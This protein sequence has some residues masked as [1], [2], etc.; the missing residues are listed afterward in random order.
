[1]P[2]HQFNTKSSSSINYVEVMYKTLR[3]QENQIKQRLASNLKAQNYLRNVMNLER[4][5]AEESYNH[6]ASNGNRMNM[7]MMSTMRGDILSQKRATMYYQPPTASTTMTTTNHSTPTTTTTRR[8]LQNQN[9]QKQT[10]TDVEL[11]QQQERFHHRAKMMMTMGRMNHSMGGTAVLQ[12]QQQQQPSSPP[13]TLPNYRYMRVPPSSPTTTTTTTPSVSVA[14]ASVS[15]TSAAGSSGIVSPVA[16][17][18]AATAIGGSAAAAAGRLTMPVKYD[19]FD[20][21]IT[22]PLNVDGSNGHMSLTLNVKNKSSTDVRFCVTFTNAQ[23]KSVCVWPI[24]SETFKDLCDFELLEGK[25]DVSIQLS[26]RALP[27]EYLEFEGE[28]P[29]TLSIILTSHT[30]MS[31]TISEVVH[32]QRQYHALLRMRQQ[33]EQSSMD[34]S[35]TSDNGNGME[36][37]DERQCN[38][39]GRTAIIRKSLKIL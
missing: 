34:D 21:T 10:T 9:E 25:R 27:R 13:C 31:S 33:K 26:T 28:K 39:C 12:Q 2:A 1:M 17:A 23:G 30:A 4:K 35:T 3:K 18:S 8:P 19:H 7:M 36:D 22:K 24:V 38:S 32:L 6:T 29:L 11:S 15:T 16:A 14:S 20:V 5:L 37:D